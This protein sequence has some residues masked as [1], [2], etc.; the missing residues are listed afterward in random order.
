VTDKVTKHHATD[1]KTSNDHKGQTG[2]EDQQIA[3][4][5]IAR[6]VAVFRLFVRHAAI[7]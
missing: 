1:D 7:P 3:N 6:F 5:R 4:A 2:A